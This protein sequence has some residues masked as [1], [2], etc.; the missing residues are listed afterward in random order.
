MVKIRCFIGFFVPE[1]ARK[2]I[3]ELQKSV[4]SLPASC[5]MVEAE[6]LHICL[7]FLGNVEKNEA[8]DI[9]KNLDEVCSKYSSFEVGIERIKLIPSPSYVRVIVLSVANPSD[10]LERLSYEIKEK[11]GGSVKP[12]HITLCRVRSVSDKREFLS[13]VENLAGQVVGRD[14]KFTVG[15]IAIIKSELSPEGPKYTVFK[16][17]KLRPSL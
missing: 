7:S 5:K 14:T 6:N 11:V 2:V 13:G 15:S 17:F 4:K 1:N 8:E 10:A 12:P 16:E 9:L 3:T